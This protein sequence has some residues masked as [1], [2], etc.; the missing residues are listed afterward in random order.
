[1]ALGQLPEDQRDRGRAQLRDLSLAA[2]DRE[3]CECSREEQVPDTHRAVP[4]RAG[5][6]RGAATADG[7]TVQD[8]VVDQSRHVDQLDRDAR[9][10]WRL[11]IASAR[12]EDEQRPQALAAR[13]ERLFADRRREAGV[14]GDRVEESV[15]D[16]L[17]VAIEPLRLTDG[18]QRAQTATPVCSATMP[19]AK[20]R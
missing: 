17:Q 5:D 15:L 8:V 11:P 14:A 19:P 10:V 12:K 3:L 16:L 1:V 7:G 9:G 20:S 4:A 18:R 6:D 13:G 2:I